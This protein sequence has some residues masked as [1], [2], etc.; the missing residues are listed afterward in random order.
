LAL[1][2]PATAVGQ[3]VLIDRGVR[4]A[5]LW[6]FPLHSDTLRYVYLPARAR[7]ALDD[8]E[9]PQ[10]SF[11]RYVINQ[12]AGA[13]TGATISS[14][15]GGGIL[16]FLVLYET[17]PE[18]VEAAERTLQEDLD[19]EALTLSGPVIFSE[20][21]YALIS[22]ILNPGGATQRAVLATGRAPV[23]EGNRI[24]LSFE[25]SPEKASLL[26]ES[27][28]MATPDVSL[29]FDMTFS[30]LTEAYDAELTIDW[31]EVR[32][33]VGYEA[34]GSIYFV[35][36]DVEVALDS[37]WRSNA[38]RLRS[39]GSD[40]SMEALLNTVYNKLLELLF[41]PVEPERLP[42]GSR[43]DLF[44]ALSAITDTRLG[45][46]KLTGFG[47]HA[48]YQFKEMRSGGTSVLNFNHRS[49]VDRHSVITF[50]IGDFYARFGQD[51]TYFRVVNLG[52]P[53]YD[54]RN[55][56]VGLDG[57]L[58]P[59]FDEYINSVT[60]TL[61]KVHGDG[62]TTLRE[63]IINRSTPEEEITRLGMTY[64]WSHDDDRL[65]WLSYEYRTKWSFEG[66]G[67]Y[68]SDWISSDGSQI[69]LYAPYERRSVQLV[70]DTQELQRH[71][72]RAVI[73]YIE[74]PFFGESRRHQLVFRPGELL[75]DK[76]VEITLPRD[77]FTYDYRIRW[78]IAGDQI[79]TS[80][81]DDSGLVFI[82]EIPE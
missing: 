41:R 60:V 26:L 30:G 23:L 4:A 54:L 1:L 7:L 42:E 73:V 12:P 66:G 34:G 67:S 52:D 69:N 18:A 9:R 56:R 82:D 62:T 19:N 43:G 21:R 59:E 77:Q 68:E 3:Q 14:A 74:Y 72:V 53:V 16:H 24:A 80:G 33:S 71:G 36:A 63:L 37:M 20:G 61:R 8:Q 50:N 51:S 79:E 44:D 13:E 76:L 10:F 47:F 57:A 49:T 2:A 28:K 55:I 65:E 81:S 38:I 29:A 78:L 25:L 5:D 70:G 15:G 45:S 22:S 48:G 31:A 32:K 64:G 6:C 40:E 35:S 58:L 17:P 11:V 46:R 27:F 39:S 75:E